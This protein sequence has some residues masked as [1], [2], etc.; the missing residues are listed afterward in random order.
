MTIY[1]KIILEEN[2]KIKH[3]RRLIKELIN[4]YNVD[5]LEILN[6]MEI[7]KKYINLINVKWDTDM[8]IVVLKNTILKKNYN[9]YL[10]FL[11]KKLIL[12][13][14]TLFEKVTLYKKTRFIIK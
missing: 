4:N 3:I 14:K 2:K 10:N 13:Q 1:L 8:V 7:K 6:I 12:L 9:D 11:D 5:I